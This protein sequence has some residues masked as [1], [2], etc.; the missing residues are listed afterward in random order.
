MVFVHGCIRMNYD[1][2]ASFHFYPACTH[3]QEVANTIG[4]IYLSAKSPD[5]GDVGI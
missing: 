3:A 5:L 2:V 1:E 4:S